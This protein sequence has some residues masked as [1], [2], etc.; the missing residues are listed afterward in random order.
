[1]TNEYQFPENEYQSLMTEIAQ[2]PLSN[3]EERDTFAVLFSCIDNTTLNGTDSKESVI[4]FV[5]KTQEM[6][7]EDLLHVAA[8]CVYPMY[9]SDVKNYLKDSTIHVAAVAGGFPAGQIPSQ[10]KTD[11]VRYVINSGADEVDFVI[12]RGAFL[13]GD[14]QQVFDEIAAAKEICGTKLLKVIIETGE[15]GTSENIY[16]ASLLALEAGAD[17]I[18]TSTGKISVGATPQSAFVMLSAL[19]DFCKNYK[20]DAGFKVAGGLSSLSEALVYYRLAKKILFP[21]IIS[22]QNFRI[23]TSRLTSQMFNFLTQQ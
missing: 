4:K 22:N 18:K 2:C 1:M 3:A 23:G 13:C 16:N 9:V 14:K 7:V 15:L 5:Q 12:N 6:C 19:R 10:L 20:K 21:K 17:F 8:V 11:E